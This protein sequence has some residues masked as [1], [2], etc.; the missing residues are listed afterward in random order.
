MARRASID[1][2]FTGPCEMESL[3]HAASQLVESLDLERQLHALGHQRQAQRV[4]VADDGPRQ[5]TARV[6]IA[7]LRD[8]RAGD[9]QDVDRAVA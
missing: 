9:L 7:E 6:G 3:G 5:L 2:S 1:L 8:Q 4:A